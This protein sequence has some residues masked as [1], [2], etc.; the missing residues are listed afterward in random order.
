MR[1][2]EEV[3][4][5][6]LQGRTDDPLH[7]RRGRR[8]DPV[9]PAPVQ[10]GLLEVLGLVVGGKDVSPQPFD[11]LLGIGDRHA[12]EPEGGADLFAVPLAAAA[13]QVVLR[14]RVRRD[15]ELV[16]E[17]IPDGGG[18]LLPVAGEPTLRPG[19]TSARWQSR[20][21]SGRFGL[22]SS[23]NSSAVRDQ[24][25]ASSCSSQYRFTMP[26]PSPTS[27]GLR[28][29]QMVPR[30]RV[31]DGARDGRN[32]VGPGHH[33]HPRSPG[34]RPG[35]SIHAGSGHRWHLMT[36]SLPLGLAL[37]ELAI[38]GHCTGGRDRRSCGADDLGPA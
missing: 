30:A 4:L 29:E 19:R 13:R 18:D 22:A 38:P 15:P 21:G 32:G 11:Q 14:E 8:L 28:D 27:S 7:A 31:R 33:E 26:S 16:G 3:L 37:L 10:G 36:A 1:R 23:S 9:P 34:V 12:P 6:R 17:V 24:C 35:G 20:V 5:I 2:R 25:S